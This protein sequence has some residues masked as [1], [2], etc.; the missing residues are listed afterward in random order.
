MYD[1]DLISTIEGGY[2]TL[3]SSILVVAFKIAE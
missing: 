3:A 2:F 1:Y